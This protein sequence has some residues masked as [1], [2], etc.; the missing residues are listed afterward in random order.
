MKRR[1]KGQLLGV[2]VAKR[3]LPGPQSMSL[4]TSQVGWR[5]S[6]AQSGIRIGKEQIK[7][8]LFIPL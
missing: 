6:A 8:R 7:E 5:S 1:D 3:E 4:G 2:S